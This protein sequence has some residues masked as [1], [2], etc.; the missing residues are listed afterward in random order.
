MTK[1]HSYR[2]FLACILFVVIILQSGICLAQPGVSQ[3]DLKHIMPLSQVKRGMRGYGLTVFHGTKVEKFDVEVLGVLKKINTG[4]DLILV[5]IGGGPITSRETGIIAGMSG[6]PCYINGK[7]IG[8]I[9]YGSG[10]AKEPIGMLTPIEDMLEAWDENLPKHASG[11]SSTQS[12]PEPLTIDGR[13]VNRISIVKPG[14]DQI[15]ESSNGTL[16]MQPLMTPLMVSGLSPRGIERLAEILQPFHIRPIAGPGGGGKEG[17]STELVPGS[18]VGMSLARGDIDLTAIGTLTYRRGNRLLAFGHPMLGIGAIDAPMTAAFVDDIISSYRTSVK[19]ASPLQTVGRIFQD[20]PWSIAGVIGKYAKTIPVTI[21][22]DDRMFKRNRTFKVSVINHPLLASRILTLIIGEAIYN[23]HP[24]PGDATAEVSYEVVADQIGKI[25]RSNVFFDPVSIDGAAISDI[26]SLL[27][28]LST[29]RFYPLDIKSVDV[30]VRIFDKRNTAT[31]DRIFVK[32]SE[33]EPGETV[34]VGVVLRPYKQERIVKTFNVR[35]PATAADGKVTLLVRGGGTPTT[36]LITQNTASDEDGDSSPPSTMPPIMGADLANADNVKQL[37]NRYLERERNNDIVVQLMMRGTAINVAGEKLTGL[38]TAI[39]DVMKSSRNSGLK[40]ERDEVKVKFPQDMIV[41]G[42]AALTLNVKRKDL[43]D[44]KSPGITRSEEGSESDQDSSSPSMS[45]SLE[46]DYYGYSSN[47]SAN[48]T[49][50]NFVSLAEPS[51]SVTEEDDTSP[52]EA[53]ELE[54]ESGQDQVKAPQPA[55]TPPKTDVKTVVRQAKTWTQRTQADF[56]KGTFSGVSASSKNRLELAPTLRKLVDTPEQFVWCTSPA[57]NGI[58]AGTGDS[59][60]IYY[61]TDSGEAKVFYETGELE[62][63]ALIGDKAGNLYA[64]TSPHGKVFKIT[65]E[66]KGIEIFKAD[67][68]YIMALAI[69]DE[70]NLYAGTGDAGK[71]YRIDDAESIDVKANGSASE[72]APNHKGKEFAVLSEQQV[73]SLHWDKN[74]SLIV[75][76]GINGVVYRIDKSGRA[77][78]IFDANEDSITAVKS[79]SQG[80]VYVGTSPKGAVYKISPNGRSKPVF[81]KATRV[82]SIVCDNRDNIYAVSDGTV[83]RISPDETVIQLDSAQDKV[84]FLSLAF[85]E[86]T[87]TLYA[88]TGNIGSVYVSK[89]CEVVGEYESPVHDTGMISRWGRIKW[90]AD[91]PEGTMVELQTRTG[92]VSNPD[93]TWSAWSP[94][95]TKSTGEQIVGADARYIQYRVTLKT[96]KEGVSPKV[97]SVTI[98]YLTPNQAPSVKLITPIGGE[99]WS[100]KETIRWTSNDPDKDMLTYDIYYSSNGGKEW[101]LLAGVNNDSAKPNGLPTENEIIGKVKSELEKSPD[102]PSEMKKEILK[103]QPEAA[104]N[105]VTASMPSAVETSSNKT[106]H[107][108]DTS[109]VPDGRYIIKV[110]ASDRNSNPVDALTDESISGTFIICNT[111][112]KLTIYRKAIEIKGA[113]TASIEGSVSSELTDI[114]GVQ[115]RVDGGSWTA[116]IARDGM[117]DS[118]YEAFTISTD[119]LAVGTHKIEVQGIDSAGNATNATVEVKVS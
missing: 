43:K 62:V 103:E 6:S 41:S 46:A 35:I 61:I 90:D 48:R 95:Y 42:S 98:T 91:T 29:N 85:N 10:Y 26:G 19:L 73:L 3:E 116:A 105:K 55:S 51:V 54:P 83:V 40:M 11:Y 78:P 12:L 84:Q 47:P 23:A 115:Y 20:R 39:A 80:N 97:G 72:T 82:L 86:H 63:H 117:F 70:G 104:K 92:N 4:K 112:P 56:A 14:D 22:I 59:G 30:K 38:P 9:S 96:D 119:T 99:V 34:E 18:A 79:D 65:P 69:D 33:Y 108:W 5:R 114:A 58:Y 37:I 32:E 31:I 77:E 67:E 89:C 88:G 75:G 102:V 8:A 25:S 24:T 60:R 74:R 52:D 81:S 44:T 36:P 16:Y 27:N 107:T 17:I 50:N 64:G 71:I 68:K 66:G 111:P 109:T 57:K 49:G 87:N 21:R 113:G 7:L 106:S 93:A 94:P 100:G 15:D 53:E 110:V 101:K 13:R 1:K 76:T 118:P 28:L 2:L 45:A